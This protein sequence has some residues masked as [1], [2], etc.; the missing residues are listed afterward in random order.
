MNEF[1]K[2]GQQLEMQIAC[3][4]AEIFLRKE[5][6]TGACLIQLGFVS[7]LMSN[8]ENGC[9]EVKRDA[10][11]CLSAFLESD[12]RA[13]L[14]TV[15]EHEI[16]PIFL[17]LIEEGANRNLVRIV[18]DFF[19]KLFRGAQFL[20]AINTVLQPFLE[21]GGKGIVTEWSY[22][23]DEEIAQIATDFLVKYVD[24]YSVDEDE[25]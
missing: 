16:V 13:I 14:L 25:S 8:V 4:G 20:Q 19:F 3:W 23:D 11:C 24:P 17:E 2:T 15:N 21:R 7:D 5:R 12:L 22:D 18:L 6:E 1:M 9:F 10:V